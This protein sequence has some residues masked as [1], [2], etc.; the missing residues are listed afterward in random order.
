VNKCEDHRGTL[1]PGMAADVAVFSRD[2]LT[3][4]PEAILSD[5]RCD[6]TILGGACVYDATGEWKG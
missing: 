3:A 5:T 1:K 2:L 6:L 4:T